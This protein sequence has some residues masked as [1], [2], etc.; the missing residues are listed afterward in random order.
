MNSKF[1][2]ERV[3]ETPFGPIY[4]PVVKVL[5]NSIKKGKLVE[6]TMIVDTGAD[7]TILP[8][9]IA[10]KLEISLRND[11]SKQTTQGVGGN[12]ITYICKQKVRVQVGNM[13]RMVPIAF[14]DN[15]EVPPLLGRLGFLETFNAEFLKTHT[16]VFKD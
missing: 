7:F 12:Q 8:R 9:Y 1:T 15:D 3:G 10:R 2:Y 11:Y 14:L 6:A 4:R 5:L 13:A 16:V